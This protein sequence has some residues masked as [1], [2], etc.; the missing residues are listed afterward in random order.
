MENFV[1]RIKQFA[2][3]FMQDRKGVTALE[4]ALVAAVLVTIIGY[5]F[6]SL[7]TS[8]NTAFIDIGSGL[9]NHAK[10]ASNS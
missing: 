10:A 4:Y 2:R 9:T 6:T 5:A 7:G 1:F 8:L 3:G